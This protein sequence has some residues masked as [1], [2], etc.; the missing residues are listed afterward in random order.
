MKIGKPLLSHLNATIVRNAYGRRIRIP[1]I[2]GMK[3]GVTNEPWMFDI[4]EGLLPQIEGG[5]VDVGANLGQT[6]IKF[7]SA[8][9]SRPYVGIEP[10]AFCLHYL[11]EL[12]LANRFEARFLPVGLS[13]QTGLLSFSFFSENPADPMATTVDGFRRDRK[14]SSEKLIPVFPL[15]EIIGELPEKVGIVKIDVEG[16]ELEALTGMAGFIRLQSPLILI[17]ILPVYNDEHKL[18]YERQL[19]IEALFRDWGYVINRVCKDNANRF[20]RF[21]RVSE[22]GVHGTLEGCD[23][24]VCPSDRV[25]LLDR[26][27]AK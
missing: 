3:V 27:G 1:L 25:S 26:V 21:E 4:I 14:I 18:R 7:R 19:K 11:A 22:I 16:G 23:Y 9:A 20:D 15:D 24:V 6:L 2:S 5:F 8:D 12:N 17:E 10:N 13:D